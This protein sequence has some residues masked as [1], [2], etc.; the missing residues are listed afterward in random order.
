[1][2]FGIPGRPPARLPAF[3]IVHLC[4]IIASQITDGLAAVQLRPGAGNATPGETFKRLSRSLN[5]GE[6]AHSTDVDL[7]LDLDLD[8]DNDAA[9]DDDDD[10]DMMAALGIL[11][12]VAEADAAIDDVLTTM[13]TIDED[14]EIESGS[15]LD[16]RLS[17]QSADTADT[18]DSGPDD[19]L[20]DGPKPAVMKRKIAASVKRGQ[21]SKDTAL[22]AVQWVDNEVRKLAKFIQ[23]HGTVRG[24][25]LSPVR[26]RWAFHAQLLLSSEHTQ[27]R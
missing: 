4:L 7:D 14:D 3:L 1:L 16:R 6:S 23:D 22:V 8:L 11:D 25:L 26:L 20:E 27:T 12:E 21:V 2:A 15:G 24:C 19:D 5:R 10:G 17:S 9:A 18:A 13:M